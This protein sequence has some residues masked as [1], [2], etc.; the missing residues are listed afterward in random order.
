MRISLVLCAVLVL[1]RPTPAL[2]QA[3][4]AD[5][6]PLSASTADAAHL[7]A[8]AAAPKSASRA[9]L[10]SI[11]HMAVASSVGWLLMRDGVDSQLKGDVGYWL[12]AYGAL[13]AP[14]AGNFYAGDKARVKRGLM[15]RSAGGALVAASMWRQIFTTFNVDNPDARLHWDALNATGFAIITAGA[16]YSLATAPASVD[17]Y[18][19]K[20]SGDRPRVTVA[21]SFAPAT[22]AAGIQVEVRF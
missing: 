2:P 11:G 9:Q 19:R 4:A 6:A 18:N 12:F 5:A 16:A 20:T 3:T 17:A 22:L 15:I 1:A 8:P 21:P 10:L 13:V 7:S 14:S